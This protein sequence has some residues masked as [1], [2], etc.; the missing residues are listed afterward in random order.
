MRNSDEE[1]L[2]D[3]AVTRSE[4]AFRVLVERHLKVAYRA[5]YR[6]TQNHATAEEVALHAFT[7][8]AL[9]PHYLR[10]RE[11][12]RSW[13]YQT[14]RN[15]GLDIVKSEVRRKRRDEQAARQNMEDDKRTDE[16]EGAIAPIV[17]AAI[18]EL[19]KQ[20]QDAVIA[21]F[22]SETSYKDI[23]HDLGV[24]E[25]A[26]RMRVQR[27]VESM[28]RYL[29][30]KG[31]TTTATALSVSLT[32]NAAISAPIGLAT[33]IS[34]NAL[35]TTT[36]GTSSLST[37]I[38]TAM[39]TKS[40]SAVAGLSLAS[41]IVTG[42][43]SYNAGER[44]GVHSAA[45]SPQST[46]YSSTYASSEKTHPKPEY[47]IKNEP[48]PDHSQPNKSLENEIQD[49]RDLTS[50]RA[51]L[52]EFLI[53]AQKSSR[54]DIV[55]FDQNGDIT[56][57]FADVYDLTANQKASL[58]QEIRTA[59]ELNYQLI[60]AHSKISKTTDNEFKIEIDSFEGG[61]KLYDK[62]LG[63][64]QETLGEDKFETF[65]ALSDQELIR[66]FDSFGAQ[67]KNLKITKKTNTD[68]EG[69]DAIR[70]HVEMKSQTPNGSM[71]SN[72][73]MDEKRF[74]KNYEVAKRLI[75]EQP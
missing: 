73:V 9:H 21:R 33:Q 26:A 71:N 6:I 74:R 50:K 75:E 35:A 66:G 49:S 29:N 55:I 16:F 11:S 17:D 56:N 37:L 15:R 4:K 1:L 64:F 18:E 12:L 7:K 68:R 53:H 59:K 27:A 62:L 30:R 3:Y 43:L 46:T 13:I 25:N 61:E 20:D 8:L 65:L 23:G 22:F 70:Y 69:D 67:V 28:R 39:K 24:S 40:I 72:V 52:R 34:A 5:A 63:N 58:S 38:L 32:A 2:K 51:Y 57:T 10:K 19:S 54:G 31:I 48:R 42:Y 45:A 41:C 60:K 47:E 14:A 36:A 44:A